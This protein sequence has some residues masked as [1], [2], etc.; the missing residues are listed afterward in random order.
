M[1]ELPTKG[2]GISETAHNIDLDLFCDWLEAS[3]LFTDDTISKSDIVDILMESEL[4]RSQ[5]FA[6]EFV[7][8]GWNELRR[9]RLL[10]ADGCP[11]SVGA[12]LKRAISWQDVP[13]HSFF[14]LVSC[15]KWYTDWA[16]QFGRDYTEQGLL[17]EEITREA[18]QLIFN[19]WQTHRTG[20]SAAN[21][22]SLDE[23]V[24]RVSG[25]LGEKGKDLQ[26]W[27]TDYANDAGLDILLYHSFP[28]DRAGRTVY[29]IQCASGNNW[30]SKRKTPDL[31]IWNKII[32][33]TSPPLRALAIPFSLLDDEFRRS[34]N[35]VEGMLL[36]RYRLLWP[37]KRTSGWMSADLRNRVVAWL[38]P[39]IQALVDYQPV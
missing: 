7:N 10:L 9:R 4:Y 15:G 31:A 39:R 35:I 14:V 6:Y 16:S 12:E 8:D 36:D 24:Q 29:L 3:I 28:D 26:P 30:T 38:T 34:A 11:F 27:T 22:D 19:D 17:F 23:I 37:G 25:L 5:D 13:A 32:E 21:A 18:V 1:I 33:F 20:W 2:V